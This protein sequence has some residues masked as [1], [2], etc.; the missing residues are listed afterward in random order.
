MTWQLRTKPQKM[1]LFLRHKLCEQ[2]GKS[3]HIQGA[4]CLGPPPPPSPNLIELQWWGLMSSVLNGEQDRQPLQLSVISHLILM[5]HKCPSISHN[6]LK[7]LE[8]LFNNNDEEHRS[9]ARNSKE[10]LA[11]NWKDSPW[12]A[13]CCI[14]YSGH[15]GALEAWEMATRTQMSR[16]LMFNVRTAKNVTEACS[17]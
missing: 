16:L 1:Y 13:K 3:R 17:A 4:A 2:E 12:V 15:L 8:P 7:Y 10:S 11:V 6:I 9:E 14:F 5:L